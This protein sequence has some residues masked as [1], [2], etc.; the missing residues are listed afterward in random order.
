[1]LHIN[2]DDLTEEHLTLLC[3][4]ETPE[5]VSIEYKRE[6]DLNSKDQ[7]LEAAKDVSAMANTV[8]GRIVY[9]IEE[10]CL[11]DGSSV[12]GA[13][14]PLTDGTLASRLEQILASTIQPRLRSRVRKVPLS[15]S[16]FVLV[17]EIYPS[18]SLDL[19]MVTGYK[20]NR[21]YRRGEQHTVLMTE[22]EIR[23]AYVRIAASR[24]ALDASIEAM[25]DDELDAIPAAFESVMVV[26]WFGRH[27]LVSPQRLGAYLGTKLF[28]KL[29]NESPCRDVV[30]ILRIVSGGYRGY[31]PEK[32][33]KKDWSYYASIRR[34]GLV[35]LGSRVAGGF[36]GERDIVGITIEHTLELALAAL[37]VARYVLDETAYWGPVRMIY[38]LNVPSPFRMWGPGIDQNFDRLR[39]VGL[40]ESG[41]YKRVVH[42]FNFR[43][44]GDKL[45]LP[46]RD[47]ADWFFQMRGQPECPWFDNSGGLTHAASAALSPALCRH[48]I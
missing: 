12:A 26:P 37:L 16:G 33:Q 9:G 3:Q 15:L 22:P 34:S 42:E 24:Q 45:N 2:L 21:F 48:L 8:G 36:V 38:R 39:G 35:H 27:D 10:K 20:D 28:N 23:E 25:I 13:I 18:W 46:L 14:R 47:L 6:L 4:N 32:S 43:E 11:P 1:M 5:S 41:E 19:H 17:V 44:H 7:R 31:L 40:I 29:L 30:G